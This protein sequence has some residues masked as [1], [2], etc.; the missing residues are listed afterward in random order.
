MRLWMQQNHSFKHFLTSA[1]LAVVCPIFRQ[2][3]NRTS[4]SILV[5]IMLCRWRT[6]QGELVKYLEEHWMPNIGAPRSTQS[7]DFQLLQDMLRTT[8]FMQVNGVKAFEI[9]PALLV[10]EQLELVRVSLPVPRAYATASELV[11][12]HGG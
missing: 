6:T 9:L 8:R 3:Y 7:D 11:S 5:I 12:I 2:M 4:S 10:R 1:L